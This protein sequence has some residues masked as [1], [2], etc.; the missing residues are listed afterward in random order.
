[1]DDS[2]IRNRKSR[3]FARNQKNRN[4]DFSA[5][6]VRFFPTLD[7]VLHAWFQSI[8]NCSW[9]LSLHYSTV[10]LPS[11]LIVT[12]TLIIQSHVVLINYSNF[13][14]MQIKFPFGLI[15]IAPLLL[16]QDVEVTCITQRN[17][18]VAL[19]RHR[20]NWRKISPDDA[21]TFRF[22]HNNRNT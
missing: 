14:L 11:V 6:F 12:V 3:F 1:M 18:E 10:P 8:T 17:A 7:V 9:R 13:L 16:K 22:R 4:L 15:N 19:H 20:G 21:L 2:W 5:I